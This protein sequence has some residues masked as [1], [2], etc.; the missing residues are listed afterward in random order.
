[1]IASIGWLHG[2]DGNINLT[3]CID[4]NMHATF[5]NVTKEEYLETKGKRGALIRLATEK[6]GLKHAGDCQLRSCLAEAGY[7]ASGYLFTGKK[8]VIGEDAID[9]DAGSLQGAEIIGFDEEIYFDSSDVDMYYGHDLL[10]LKDGRKA[11]AVTADL[12]YF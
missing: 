11:F 10:Q 5:V 8:F 3:P 1:M 4:G 6:L 9:L 12:D 7:Y 2:A